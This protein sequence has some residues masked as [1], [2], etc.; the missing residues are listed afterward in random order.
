MIYFKSNQ[1]L[2]R[3]L[4]RAIEK[5]SNE[6]IARMDSDDISVRDRFEHQLKYMELNPEIDIIGGQIEEFIGDVSNTVGKRKVP[7]TDK[8]LKDYM[9]KRCPFNHMTVMYKKSAILEAGNYK[10][11]P[12]NEDYYLWIRMALCGCTFANLPEVLVDVRVG[13]EMYDRRGGLR[14]FQSEEQIQR[15]MLDKGIISVT[16]YMVNVGER[17]VLQVLMPN[18]M[19]GWM[20]QKFAREK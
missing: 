5:C 10:H 14:Y 1:G 11:W 6:I 7:L 4:R 19:R 12:S 3:G 9:Q 17:L 15:F 13:K 16:R 8:D 20:F 18:K 2:G